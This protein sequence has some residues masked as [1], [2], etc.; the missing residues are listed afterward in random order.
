MPI[1]NYTTEVAASKSVG[2]ISSLL[3]RNKVKHVGVEYDGFGNED[4][5]T[6]RLEIE[7]ME[8]HFRVPCNHQ[9][10]LAVMRKQGVRL[11][12]LT[13][14]QARRVAWRI[15]KQAIEV[16]L[17]RVECSQAEMGEVMFEYLTVDRSGLTVYKQF[18]EH[19]QK[20]LTQKAS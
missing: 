5:I 3:V 8:Y 6:F 10:V 16:Q 17:A 18:K 13:E 9:Q 11:K 14:A 15:I 7:G 19:N 20:L 4:A 1:L 12:L 2:E